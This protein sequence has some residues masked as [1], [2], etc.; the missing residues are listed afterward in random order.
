MLG[1]GSNKAFKSWLGAQG[2]CLMY[3]LRCVFRA[4]VVDVRALYLRIAAPIL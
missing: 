2:I 3:T 1:G 4:I